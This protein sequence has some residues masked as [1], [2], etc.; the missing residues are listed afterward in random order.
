MT[1][2]PEARRMLPGDFQAW[3]ERREYSISDVSRLLGVTRVSVRAWCDPEGRGPPP[4][5]TLA[6]EALETRKAVKAA[7]A[8]ED[9]C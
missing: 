4:H 6:I 2:Y 8:P 1:D 7:P 5:I 3:M 9:K